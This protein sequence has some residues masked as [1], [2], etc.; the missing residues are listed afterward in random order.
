MIELSP[1][2]V[3]LTNDGF[4]RRLNED[5]SFDLICV[6]CYRTVVS[7]TV[8]AEFEAHEL[9]HVC[10]PTRLADIRRMLFHPPVSQSI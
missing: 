7:A 2:E 4:A 9:S 5:G 6:C 10:D 3:Y 8:T 1:E